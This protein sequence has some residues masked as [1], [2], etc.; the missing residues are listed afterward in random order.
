MNDFKAVK[1]DIVFILMSDFVGYVW[2]KYTQ[3]INH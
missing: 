1:I 2:V 3:I